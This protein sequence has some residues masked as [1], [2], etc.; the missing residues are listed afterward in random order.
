M[1]AVQPTPQGD[2]KVVITPSDYKKVDGI[3]VPHK[4]TT[5]TAQGDFTIEI[6]S[7][8]FN[9]AIGDDKFKLPAEIQKLVDDK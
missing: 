4:Q 3:N 8:E 6:D 5:N 1:E 2:M 9:K 7:I